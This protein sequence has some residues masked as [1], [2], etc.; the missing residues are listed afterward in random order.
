[1]DAMLAFGRPRSVELLVLVDRKHKRQLPVEPSYIGIEV[2][3][4]ETEHVTVQLTE[5]GGQDKVYL[6]EKE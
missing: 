5:S 2:E 3:T 6:V 4:I 1:M